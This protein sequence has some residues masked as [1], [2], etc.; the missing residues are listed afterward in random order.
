MKKR[1]SLSLLIVCL[2]MMFSNVLNAQI[3]V[4]NNQLA[5]LNIKSP[6][7]V[8]D[9]RNVKKQEIGNDLSALRQSKKIIG[10]T[11][12][13]CKV[14]C[15]VQDDADKFG[16]PNGIFVTGPNSGD[17]SRTFKANYPQRNVFNCEMPAGTYDFVCSAFCKG[18]KETS[19]AGM[20]VIIKELLEIKNDT[21]IYFNHA[22]ATNVY[23][24]QTF[25]PNGDELVLS[26]INFDEDWMPTDTIVKGNIST[27][28]DILY[29][30]LVSNV[31]NGYAVRYVA[32]GGYIADGGTPMSDILI[33]DVSDRYKLVDFRL[34]IENNDESVFFSKYETLSMSEH[35]LK[36]K[37]NGYV[38]YEDKFI[39]SISSNLDSDSNL[40]GF[41]IEQA[42]DD[43]SN[44]TTGVETIFKS[45]DGNVMTYV[46]APKSIDGQS[47]F[48][49][50]ITPVFADGAQ[51]H[52]DSWSWY[53]ENGNEHVEKSTY[54]TYSLIN[55]LPIIQN[56]NEEFEYVNKS[57]GLFIIPEGGGNDVSI[58][59]HPQFSYLKDK[60][61]TD[62]GSSCPI[63]SIM[64][65]NTE[66]VFSN[67]KRVSLSCFCLGRNGELRNTDLNS[68]QTEIKYNDKVVYENDGT[69][70]A[71]SYTFSNGEQPDGVITAHFVNENMMV[72]GLQGK[73]ITDIYFD[74]RQEDWTAPTL[75]MLLFKDADGNIT[76]RF[77][78]PTEGTLE[79]AGGDF[80]YKFDMETYNSWYDCKPQ[81]V[82]VS[83]A[84]YGDTNWET[85]DVTEIPENFFMP[86]FGYFYRGSLQ[87]VTGQGWFDLKIKLTDLSGNWQEQVI[88]PA[89]RIGDAPTGIGGVKVGNATE[90]A[91]YTIDGRAISIPQAGVNI[92]KMS[93]GTV[94]KVLVK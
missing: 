83:Y 64:A 23:T 1:N 88:S 55:G 19:T 29:L 60:K 9:S 4:E 58:I 3:V 72:D 34:A 24:I 84:P 15:I 73:N 11:E 20:A 65:Q 52:V 81:S 26:N 48:D 92:I 33:N 93:D 78:N 94:K 43:I 53:D 36:S 28:L 27:V 41:N 62:Y 13:T 68:M 66:G 59:G 71:D 32:E 57:N 16:N 8:T 40:F 10:T 63:N 77:D 75:Q 42:I 76:D 2:V 7:R 74:Q 56:T 86:G 6:F 69:I 49:M 85:L 14:T 50:Y 35:V 90:V 89:F 46:D 67:G 31:D 25:K 38:K 44:Y 30:Q 79:F 5:K 70:D 39:P 61:L 82:E 87:N 37:T 91:R 21:T 12:N 80:D 47:R 18:P 51:E 17:F 54:Y 22:D 45:K